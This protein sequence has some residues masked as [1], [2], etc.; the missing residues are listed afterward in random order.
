MSDNSEGGDPHER[1]SHERHEPYAWHE[2]TKHPAQ[3]HTPSHAGNG[4]VNHGPDE[5][6]PEGLG[7]KGSEELGQGLDGLA[8]DEQALRRLLHTAVDD[9]EPRVGT[10][11]HLRRAVPA[12]RA[13]K[14]QA[15]VGMAA[16]ALFFGTAIPALVHVSNSGG[17][18]PNT[19]M[20]GQSSQ[21]QGGNGQSKHPDGGSSGSGGSH[22]ETPGPGKETGK[23]EK[24]DKPGDSG[25]G[26]T[27]GADPAAT[28]TAGILACTSAQLGATGTADA[29]DTA[30]AVYGTF[31]V[32]NVSGTPCTVSGGVTVSATAQ[33]AADQ[34]KLSVTQHVAGDPAAGLPDPTLAVSSLVLQPGAAYTEKF[35]FVPSE[36]CPPAGGPSSGGS[37]SGGPS[38]D[39]SPSQDVSSGGGGSTDPGTSSGVTTQLTTEEGTADGSVVVTYTGETGG[40]SATA[41]VSNACAGTVY[42]TGVLAGS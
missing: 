2:P 8:Q 30:G 39:P 41:L 20:A 33:G 12:R 36:T 27:S 24:P 16:A 23:P 17:T 25:T 10:L 29:P 13:R 6:G 5:K 32:T 40:S 34:T 22:G 4:T 14:R 7:D 31:R 15:A 26:A 1:L 28:A 18:D 3:D 19:A 21:S 35:A 42:Y 38:P 37:G 11:D 9:I